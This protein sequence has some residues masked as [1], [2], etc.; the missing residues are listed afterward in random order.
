MKTLYRVALLLVVA[1]LTACAS[2][3]KHAEVASSIP[4]L[5]PDQ[6]RVYVYRSSSMM[7]AAIQPNVLVNGKVAGESKPGG[8]F[9]VDLPAGPIEVA[10]S[11]EVEKK[12]SFTLSAGQIRY[13]RT[14]IGFGL[15]VGRVYPELVDNAE[16]AKQ[17][18]ETS[19]I[20]AP[21]SKR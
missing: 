16:G 19:Y 2:G 6:G 8:F 15:M 5:K 13:V 17:L 3:P 9:F 11:T 7:G 10:T 14:S 18:A 21:L 4:G 20:G 12:L 1:F